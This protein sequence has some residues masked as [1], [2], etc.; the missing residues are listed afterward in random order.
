VA[1]VG[2]LKCYAIGG[3]TDSAGTAQTDI[4]QEELRMLVGAL[5][6]PGMLPHTLTQEP[7]TNGWRVRQNTGADMNIKIGS[8]VSKADAY[9]L[10]GGVAG[11]GSY[12]ARLD[13][14]GLVVSVPATDPG[15]AQRY[16]VY[17]FVDDTAYAGTASRAY[18]GVSC[19]R[20]TPSGSPATPGPLAVWSASA[21]LWEFQLPAAA[22]AVTDV[23][24]DSATSIDRRT[25]A[26]LLPQNFLENQVFS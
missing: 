15:L 26:D 20:G 3:R 6:R 13:S 22:P 24:L 23:I 4:D 9:V 11:Q 7:N 10:R 25:T 12:L 19:L 2:S 18:A 21:L 5:L 8:T 14:V 16:G 1:A 17:L